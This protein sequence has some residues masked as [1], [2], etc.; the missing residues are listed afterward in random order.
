MI[1]HV[2][3][4]THRKIT[5]SV[6][7]SDAE[8]GRVFHVSCVKCVN[9]DGQPYGKQMTCNPWQ[10]YN[11]IYFSGQSFQRDCFSILIGT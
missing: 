9:D 7:T 4:S 1:I 3:R 6:C 5:F 11:L 2:T 10:F 8:A